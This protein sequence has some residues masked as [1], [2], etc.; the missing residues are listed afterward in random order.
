[1]INLALPA[2]RILNLEL[3]L[4]YGPNAWRSQ[5]QLL[6]ATA[7]GLQQQL[8]GL[9]DRVNTTNR[10]R[11]LQQ[12]AAGALQAV[13]AAWCAEHAH[14]KIKQW[15]R[16][17]ATCKGSRARLGCLVLQPCCSMHAVAHSAVLLL[18]PAG[19]QLA[20]LQAQWLQL[21]EKNQAIDDACSRLEQQVAAL[22]CAQQ[23][24]EQAAANGNAAGATEVGAVWDVPLQYPCSARSSSTHTRCL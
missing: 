22:R 2:P 15:C 9:K 4:K 11:K 17:W 8:S 3:L 23:G 16:W 12:E 5:N 18:L 7:K 24:Q 6:D 20:S 14:S 13:A 10:E 19:Q 21:V 1:M